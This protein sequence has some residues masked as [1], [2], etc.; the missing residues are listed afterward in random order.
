[1]PQLGVGPLMG[2]AGGVQISSVTVDT[3]VPVLSSPSVAGIQRA[4]I[5]PHS[6]ISK[7]K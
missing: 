3:G 2:E 4:Q 7:Q 5:M 1:M 6:S